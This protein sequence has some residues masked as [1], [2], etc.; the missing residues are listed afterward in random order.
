MANP[1]KQHYRILYYRGA[2]MITGVGDLYLDAGKAPPENTA[3]SFIISDG[4]ANPL[5]WNVIKDTPYVKSLHPHT[6]RAI[7]LSIAGE[8]IQADRPVRGKQ[9]MILEPKPHE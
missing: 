9:A 2:S 8:H 1:P 3:G 7:E 5:D 6:Q 4:Q